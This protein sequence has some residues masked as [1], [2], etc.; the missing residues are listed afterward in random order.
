MLLFSIIIP[1]YN[2]V[3]TLQKA[4]ESAISQSL[5][6]N[7]YE[8]III[9]DG[10]TDKTYCL[11]EQLAQNANN[12]RIFKNEYNQG[13]GI[14]RNK[15]IEKASGGYITFLDADDLLRSDA[16]EVFYNHVINEDVEVIYANILKINEFGDLLSTPA[17][18]R[19]NLDNLEQKTLSG[20]NG[21]CTVGAVYQKLFLNTNNVRFVEGHFYEDVEFVI[22]CALYATKVK[23][24]N[25]ILYYWISRPGSTTNSMSLG[26][27]RDA[28][29][30]FENI[31][32]ILDNNR[33]LKRFLKDWGKCAT[34]FMRLTAERISKF[35]EDPMPLLVTF[36]DEIKASEIFRKLGLT[37]DLITATSPF[38]IHVTANAE[39]SDSYLENLATCAANAVVMFAE[40]DYHVRNFHPIAIQLSAL[41]VKTCICDISGSGFFKYKRSM[42]GNEFTTLASELATLGNAS[43][44]KLDVK[45][46]PPVFTNARAFIFSID[47]G[48][49]RYLVFEAKR[50]GIP[51]IALYEGISD[52][53]L[54]EPPTKAK[55]LPYRNVDHL[56]VPGAYY[57]SIYAKQNV[58]VVGMP[59]IERLFLEPVLFPER[60]TVLINVNFTYRVLEERRNDF[61]QSAVEACSTAG[62]SF[63]FS[64]H[65]ADTGDLSPYQAEADSIYD[66]I[67]RC[68]VLIS[69][70]STCILEALALGKPVIY[71]NPHGERFPKFQQDPMGAFRIARTTGELTKALQEIESEIQNGKDY[72][73]AAAD[74]LRHHAN[75]FSGRHS[76]CLAAEAIQKIV[77]NNFEQ[78]VTRLIHYSARPIVMQTTYEP[79]RNYIKLFCAHQ[80]YRILAFVLHGH[81][82]ETVAE[83]RRACANKRKAIQA[84]LQ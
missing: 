26:K 2:A 78:F 37:G 9:D 75:V 53:N 65:P 50:L 56:L 17:S 60:T 21:F 5:D 32:Q 12:I 71:H 77:E 64:Q 15:A 22:K 4:V 46:Y 69:R 57:S 11:M 34:K 67:R 76:E 45:R 70:F 6:N 55:P 81:Q 47:W 49:L 43:L 42:D 74:Y 14:T 16:L 84:F 51:T 25:Q 13:Q 19:H 82:R 29:I 61:V 80:L 68:S 40:T 39:C 73:A 30:V 35:A 36:Q 52:D 79:P 27:A 7:L 44:H 58:T 63:I 18:H 62:I 31:C 72:R 54:A 59:T 83:K 66:C 48:F 23:G 28:I 41:G 20:Q 33:E 3:D 1:A 10:S 8:I 38:L 24:I